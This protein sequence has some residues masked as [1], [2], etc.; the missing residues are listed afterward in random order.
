M[1][2]LAVG[3]LTTTLLY[4]SVP[5]ME[6][7]EPNSNF[8]I[9]PLPSLVSQPVATDGFTLSA[10][11]RITAPDSLAN[12]ADLLRQ[13]INEIPG[14]KNAKD[15][16]EIVLQCTLSSDTPEAYRINVTPG[17]TI[18]DGSSSAGVFYGIQ[19]LRKAA[20]TAPTG[21]MPTLPIVTVTD[22]PRFSY[23]GAHLDVAR[24][25]FTEQD[26]K[27]YID[28]MAMHNLNTFHWH[29]TDDQ[30]WRIEIEKYPLLST[31]SSHRDSTVIGH[32]TSAYDYTP[33]D[34]IFTRQQAKD[35]VDYA[36]KRHITVIPEIDLPGH[37]VAVLAA[38]PHLGCTG[39]PYGVWGRWGVAQ[40]V[41]CAGN[42]STLIFIDDVLNE[43]MDIFPSKYVHIGGDEC[44]KTRWKECPKCQKRITELGIKPEGRFSAEDRLQGVITTHALQT[45]AAR[46]RQAI[47]WDE[48]LE[49]EIPQDA[50]IM[51]WRGIEGAAEG[52]QKGHRAILTPTAYCYLDYYQT[53]DKNDE[54][55]AWGGYVPV[56]KTYSLD[57]TEGLTPEQATLVLG[58]QGNLWT[59]YVATFPHV[60]YQVLPRMAAIAEVGWTPQSMRDYADFADRMP[61]LWHLYDTKGYNYARHMADV[62]A[63]FVTDR[64]AQHVTATL[65][66]IGT[67]KI[68]FTTDGTD[69]VTSDG[70][71]ST[72]ATLYSNPLT[73]DKSTRLKATTVFNGKPGRTL[74][75][76][77]SFNKATFGS[78]EIS[79][80]YFK[81]HAPDGPATLTDAQL[82]GPSY[83]TGQ[84]VGFK[85][86]DP[87]ITITLP[88]PSSISEVSFNVCVDMIAWLADAR[89]YKIELLAPGSTEWK[90]VESKEIPERTT[91]QPMNEIATHSVKFTPQVA[92]KVRLT[93]IST[94][95]LPEWHA[96]H[97]CHALVFIDEIGIR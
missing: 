9:I 60:Q 29:L 79:E 33:V 43:I 32:N 63:Q 57:P 93:V 58:P 18:I 76:S 59:E 88:Q 31:I 56:K 41:L 53:T 10:N 48:I 15:P 14:L 30:G 28:M 68:Y 71:P 96:D 22:A 12:E 52:T 27:D 85:E 25:P 55:A 80:P 87:A 24:H 2:K 19:T 83:L 44:P 45:L 35:I 73:F 34:G 65:S 81:H 95:Q 90:E 3:L 40:D 5:G 75:D 42:D 61:S 77:I 16:G 70:K 74:S 72:N 86:C 21:A 47:G 20:Y 78:V 97:G 46:G 1:N 17:K 94:K 8:N 49:G 36:A 39:G 38:Y 51:S 91:T 11:V 82:G 37:M 6:A 26:V 23:R 7:A 89:G 64:N 13:Y 66:T 84:W 69:P 62:D 54:P 50:I 92:E 4:V 67:G